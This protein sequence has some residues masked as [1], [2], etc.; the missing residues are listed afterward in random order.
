MKIWVSSEFRAETNVWAFDNYSF[1]TFENEHFYER[2]TRILSE[3]FVRTNARHACC[4]DAITSII[5]E[6][7]W[8][9]GYG[10]GLRIKRSS[11]RIRPWPL[12]WVVGQGSLLPL[13]QASI[14][15]LTILVK[16]I[17]AKKNK[18]SALFLEVEVRTLS[19]W[20]GTVFHSCCRVYL[21]SFSDSHSLSLTH[22]HSKKHTPPHTHTHVMQ[23]GKPPPSQP[24]LINIAICALNGWPSS[25]WLM[26]RLLLW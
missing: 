6:A 24:P 7:Q 9:I 22:M 16:Y 12:R 15:Y 13:S 23:N 3:V 26:Q 10:V 11:V 4:C 1:E 2:M 20:M 19:M 18:K 21:S 5:R 14:G 17:L 8:P 25:S